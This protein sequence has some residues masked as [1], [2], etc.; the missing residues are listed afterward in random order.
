MGH[1]Q[2]VFS[3]LPLLYLSLGIPIG[4]E[5]IQCKNKIKRGNFGT[6]L[7]VLYELGHNY[8]LITKGTKD[9]LTGYHYSDK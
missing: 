4:P 5:I 6:L 9:D 2:S 7:A 8:A 3:L 1:P